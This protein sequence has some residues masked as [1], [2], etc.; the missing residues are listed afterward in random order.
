M[1]VSPGDSSIPRQVANS[2]SEPRKLLGVTGK[3]RQDGA[4]DTPH[5]KNEFRVFK[6]SWY[7]NSQMYAGISCS[8]TDCLLS[9]PRMTG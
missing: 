5:N 2:P 6:T 1:S 3:T 8:R 9:I 7:D 4:R